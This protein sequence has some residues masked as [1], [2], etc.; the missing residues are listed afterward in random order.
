MNYENRKS[1]DYYLLL[2]YTYHVERTD[3]DGKL[4]YFA[5][6]NQIPDAH[7]YGSNPDEACYYA[8]EILIIWIKARLEH[9]DMYIPEP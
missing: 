9:Q 1:L 4:S 5:R 6:C 2:S 7:G 3:L 8:E